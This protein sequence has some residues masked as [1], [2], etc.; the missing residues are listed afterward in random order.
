MTT[1]CHLNSISSRILID[2]FLGRSH[3]LGVVAVV[4]RRLPA[5]F[6]VLLSSKW[7]LYW[8]GCGE[9][10]W[11]ANKTDQVL[12]E[13]PFRGDTLFDKQYHHARERRVTGGKSEYYPLPLPSISPSH[14]VASS[15]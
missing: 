13:L 14:S 8:V 3:G 7:S 15:A 6:R 9:A 2:S 10:A 5:G 12:A 1:H 11:S 4:T